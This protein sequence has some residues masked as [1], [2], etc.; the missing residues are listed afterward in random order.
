MVLPGSEEGVKK[1]STR[2]RAEGQDILTWAPGTAVA[3]NTGQ[4]GKC[5]KTNS[6]NRVGPPCDGGHRQG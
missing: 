5:S 6:E 2:V 4:K 3:E 1:L